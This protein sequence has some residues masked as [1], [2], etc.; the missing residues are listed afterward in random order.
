MQHNPSYMNSPLLKESLNALGKKKFTVH[1]FN[2]FQPTLHRFTHIHNHNSEEKNSWMKT[3]FTLPPLPP[4]HT[5]SSKTRCYSLKV[6]V[7]KK[8]K[9][10]NTGQTQK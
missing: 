5:P 3:L 6:S 9:P 8:K 1:N 4:T 10:Y 2:L 7:K